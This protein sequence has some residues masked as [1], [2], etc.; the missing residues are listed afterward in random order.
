[1]AGLALRSDLDQLRCTDPCCEHD[2]PPDSIA[3]E[4]TCHPD[5]AMWASYR[6]GELTL[7]CARCGRRVITIAVAG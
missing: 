5:Q 2:G 6:H 7:N 1:M 4:S 3:I